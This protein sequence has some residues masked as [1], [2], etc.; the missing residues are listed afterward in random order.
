MLPL[1]NGPAIT[2]II[3]LNLN[4]SPRAGFGKET[5]AASQAM[6]A[7]FKWW[8]LCGED[9][10]K[11]LYHIL[12][13]NASF[14]CFFCSAFFFLN[15]GESYASFELTNKHYRFLEIPKGYFELGL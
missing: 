8:A 9:A 4:I 5:L 12:L 2:C 14:L 10:L 3:S 1:I 6:R 11:G 13:E 15:L 7:R